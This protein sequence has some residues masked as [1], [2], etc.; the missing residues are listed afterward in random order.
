MV[1][2]SSGMEFPPR[3]VGEQGPAP[4]RCRFRWL[5]G[6]A[7]V[8]HE[9]IVPTNNPDHGTVNGQ[10]HVCSCGETTL[11]STARNRTYDLSHLTDVELAAVNA[12]LQ[13]L[14]ER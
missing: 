4:W 10:P 13:R 8:D 6:T 3:P 9:C 7:H 11:E 5:R 14:K 1:Q 2:W 12:R